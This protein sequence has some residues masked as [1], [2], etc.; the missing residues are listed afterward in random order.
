M[1]SENTKEIDVLIRA[2]Y[3]I[4]YLLSWEEKRVE[5]AIRQVVR[6]RDMRLFIWTETMGLRSGTAQVAQ[7]GPDESTRDPLAALEVIRTFED[8]ALFLLKDFHVF[9]SPQYQRPSTVIRKL[10]DLASELQTSYKTIVLLSPVLQLPPELEKEITVIDYDLPHLS[11]LGALLD[12]VLESVRS[13]LGV[14]IELSEEEREQVLKAALGLTLH[15]AENVFARSVVEK[16]KLDLD[17][18]IAEKEQLI[19]KT[20]LL[21]YYHSTEGIGDV[22]GLDILK[23]WL[24]ARSLAFSQKARD[25]GL[26][27]PKGL[28][29]LGVQGC[30]K[31]LTAKVVAA[32]WRLP[33]L[34]LD[35]GRVFSGLV[36]S[37]EENMRKAIKIAESVSPAVLWVDEIEKGLAGIESSGVSDAG[38]TSRVFGTLITWLQEKTAP[39]F[40]VATANDIEQLPPELLRK[41]R[42]DDIFFV[43]LPAD[44]DRKA[45]FEIHLEKRNRDPAKF[46]LDRL[47]QKSA[48]FSGAEIEQAIVAALYH[49]FEQDRELTTQDIMRALQE[50]VPLSVTM[51]PQIDYLRDWASTRARP[52]STSAP[53]LVDAQDSPP[54]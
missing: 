31:S 24:K 3:P 40:V 16:G 35:V 50:T 46:G 49:A 15:E 29:L 28:L 27:S 41:G 6:N 17:L 10:R 18:I 5:E 44:S 47:A 1:T 48:G 37:S 42:F 22:G 53:E 43:D 54:T 39:V 30:G 33:L 2:R 13:E 36:G 21:E 14:K 25:F 45:I 4:I 19:R 7:E 20:G 38:T 8:P 12:R 9:L 23:R 51:K 26:P 34:R 52:A 11:D 32:L